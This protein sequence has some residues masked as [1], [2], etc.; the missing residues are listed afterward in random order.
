MSARSAQRKAQMPAVGTPRGRA[1]PA[2]RHAAAWQRDSGFRAIRDAPHDQ[3]ANLRRTAAGRGIA[4]HGCHVT[5]IRRDDHL[6]EAMDQSRA[7]GIRR[8]RRAARRHSDST[9]GQGDADKHPRCYASQS[10][11]CPIHTTFHHLVYLTC[12]GIPLFDDSVIVSRI[13]NIGSTSIS[14]A[15]NDTVT[16]SEQPYSHGFAARPE[17][18]AQWDD[19]DEACWQDGWRPCTESPDHGSHD[20]LTA[21]HRRR[22]SRGPEPTTAISPRCSSAASRCCVARVD[23]PTCF[24]IAAVERPSPSAM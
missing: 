7:R 13:L 22:G 23:K 20:F 19:L 4:F 24:A 2:L 1:R 9:S 15:A 12:S 5:P 14:Q 18:S 8:G 11:R 17:G 6:Q 10:T 21:C 16:S 3:F